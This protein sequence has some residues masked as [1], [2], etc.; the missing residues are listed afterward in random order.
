MVVM[1][2]DALAER[3]A[4]ELRTVYR[5]SVTVVVPTASTTEGREPGRPA[6][7]PPSSPG[8]SRCS[9]SSPSTNSWVLA[10]LRELGIPVVCVEEDPEARGIPLA[11]RPRVPIVIGD[12]TDEGV[13]EAAKTDRAHSLL[14]LTSSDTT[15][16]EAT[17]YARS[18]KADCARRCASTTTRSPPPSPAPSAR[19]TRTP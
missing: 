16:L 15:N 3:L 13:L 12:V 18:V 19:P 14:A 4:A 2:D 17:L 11:R 1:G 6:G 7:A 10:Q 8:T 5:E 9:T